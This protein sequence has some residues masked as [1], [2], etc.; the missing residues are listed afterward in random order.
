MPSIRKI[1]ESGSF[2]NPAASRL[3]DLFAFKETRPGKRKRG[4]IFLILSRR[5]KAQLSVRGQL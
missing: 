4:I 5:A 3:E 2:L 1:P